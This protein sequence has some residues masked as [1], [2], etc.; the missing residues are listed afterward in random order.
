MLFRIRNIFKARNISQCWDNV[1][2]LTL[3]QF[4]LHRL[5]LAHGILNI[6]DSSSR[7]QIRIQHFFL[8]KSRVSGNRIGTWLRMPHSSKIM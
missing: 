8:E 5:D 2:N 6:L 1:S 7:A 4:Y 3:G